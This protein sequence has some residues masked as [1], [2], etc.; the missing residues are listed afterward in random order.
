MSFGNEV[1]IIICFFET[2]CLNS[3][4]YECKAC[5]EIRDDVDPYSES[6]KIGWPMY[7]VCTLIWC[8]LPVSSKNS[9]SYILGAI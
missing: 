4:L 1:L 2:G 5:L 7:L 3:I 9:T 6:P 8:V